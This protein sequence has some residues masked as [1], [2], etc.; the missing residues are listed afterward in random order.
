MSGIALLA[1][2]RR[3]APWLPFLL[4]TGFGDVPTTA[5]AFK[6]GVDEFIEKPIERE[7][8]LSAVEAALRRTTPR[9]PLLGKLFTRAETRVLYLILQGKSSKEAAY[10][11]S[12]S[13]RTIEVHRTHVMQKMGVD[14]IVD[15]IKR[16]Y[17]MGFAVPR[18]Q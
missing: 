12:R 8:L 7:T 15:T 2:V 5:K 14:N 18:S 4:V 16:A 11:L 6:M 17:E 3:R 13:V 1:E 9:D 10:L